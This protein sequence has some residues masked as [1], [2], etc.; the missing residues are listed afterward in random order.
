MNATRR[1]RGVWVVATLATLPASALLRFVGAM[2][3]GGGETYDPP[4]R[5]FVDPGIPGG[6]ELIAASPTVI[7]LVGGF[8]GNAGGVRACSCSR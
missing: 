3:A 1:D 8:I 5:P 2:A 4:P 7:A 6:W